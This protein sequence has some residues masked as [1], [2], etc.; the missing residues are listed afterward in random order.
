M[1]STVNQDLI[2]RISTIISKLIFYTCSVGLT[3][4]IFTNILNILVFLRVKIR[5]TIMGFYNILMSVFNLLAVASGF[6]VYFPMS[7]GSDISLN[8]EYAC[9][10]I[11][12]F[13]RVFVQMSSWINVMVVL[14]RTLCVSCPNRFKFLN[15]RRKLFGIVM[16]L[17]AAF[18]L[19]NVPN[20]LFKLETYL[21]YN[22]ATNQTLLI[23]ECASTNSVILAKNNANRF[24]NHIA[25][26][27]INYSHL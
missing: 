7:L 3:V 17:L 6:L 5:T 12:Y 14:D 19:L 22:N 4:I 16:G 26:H 13:C 23:L 27:F 25:S 10:L 8:S 18:A 20:L 11:S 21:V 1:P 24:A 9:V 2:M 15:D